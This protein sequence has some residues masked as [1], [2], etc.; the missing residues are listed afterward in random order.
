MGLAAHNLGAAE[1]ALGPA[2]L[3]R[4]ADE[5]GVTWLSANAC[6]RDGRTI[7]EP[8]VLVEAAG[9]R[10][11]LIGAVG[12]QYATPEID[13]TPPRQAL[14]DALREAG[15]HDVLIVLAYL[16]EEQLRELAETLPE[17]HLIVGGPTGQP[18]PPRSLGPVLLASATNQGKFLARFD[19][20]AGDA[21]FTGRIDELDG[22]YAD[23]P[24]QTANLRRFYEDLRRRDVPASATSFAPRLPDG[25]PAGFS[26]AGSE[27]C[28]PCHAE[29]HDVWKGSNHAGAWE[30][31]AAT[32]AQVD[33]ACQ[34]CHTTGY[35]LPGGFVSLGRSARHRHV[36]CESCHGPSQG[37][38]DDPKRQ[39]AYFAQARGLCIR[40]HDRENSPEFQYDTYWTRIRHGRPPEVER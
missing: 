11:L 40:C 2:Q 33:P 3:D 29:E 31:L 39:T 5:T 22:R 26:V 8:F 36:G 12:P 21:K 23:D 25:L 28:Q 35:G 20:P 9:R 14:L 13:V 27:R 7:G 6:R 16:P 4:L 32:G 10:V 15:G 30:S 18:I 1:L 37:H 38:T 24:E 34:R 17:A 19:A